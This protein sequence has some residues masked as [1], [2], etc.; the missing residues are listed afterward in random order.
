MERGTEGVRR[1]YW[2]TKRLRKKFAASLELLL[3]YLNLFENISDRDSYP[4]LQVL[5]CQVYPAF[6]FVKWMW[7]GIKYFSGFAGLE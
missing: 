7:S 4:A 6:I 1:I 3:K 5:M 2:N